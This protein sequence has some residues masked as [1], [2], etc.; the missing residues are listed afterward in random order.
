LHRPGHTGIA[1]ALLAAGSLVLSACGR[2]SADLVKGKTLFVDK[3]GACHTLA[4]AG[5][6]GTQGPNLD[7]AF[8]QDRAD[9][10]NSKT[11]RG[12]VVHQI[13]Y[14]RRGS[15]MPAKLVTGAA[16]DDVAAYVGYAAG[17]AGK[18]TGPLAAAGQVQTSNKPAVEKAGKLSID[19]VDG[20]A[21]N[22][23]SATAKAGSVTF[24]MKNTS[25]IN[26]N[27]ALKGN[28]VNAA[29]KIVN[30]GGTST[31]TVNL[32]PGKYT[33]YCQ[34]PGHEQAGMKGTLT[35]K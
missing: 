7:D 13:G 12:V 5:T 22:F 14:P 1:L 21:Y 28:G 10:M 16:A 9:G 34:V 33:F 15:I 29:G 31:F 17:K 26:H 8:V 2:D 4:R 6:K 32:K 30:Q 27:I 19:A 11:I 24:V 25:A 18:D 35:V 23:K 3:C 20:T